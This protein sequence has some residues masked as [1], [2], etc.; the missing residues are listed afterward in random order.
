MSKEETVD[1][2][3]DEICYV[4]DFLPSKVPEQFCERYIEVEEY[5][6]QEKQ[7]QQ[8]AEKFARI[9]TKLHCYHNFQIFCEKWYETISIAELAEMIEAVVMSE[10]RYMNILSE[11]EN[12]LL[13][14]EGATLHISIYNP[15]LSAVVNLS[16]LASAEGLH[17]RRAES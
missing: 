9:I 17:L 6:L 16:A 5:F 10:N 14:V 15:P 11:K 4:I 7:R 13:Q 3:L 2:L 8:Y 12:M 1:K